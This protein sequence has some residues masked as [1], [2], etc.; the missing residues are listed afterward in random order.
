MKKYIVAIISFFDNEIKQFKIEA[1]NTYEAM[2]KGMIEFC[3]EEYKKGEIAYQ[4]S[5]DYPS[6]EEQLKKYCN[7]HEMDISVIEISEF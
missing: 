3:G 1:E 7:N 2:K 6:D 4:S 5:P